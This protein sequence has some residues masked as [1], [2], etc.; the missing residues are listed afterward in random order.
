[1]SNITNNNST[2]KSSQIFK[3]L[4]R[5]KL[6]EKSP[7]QHTQR[8]S[9]SLIEMIEKNNNDSLMEGNNMNKE[10]KS[11][12]NT[13]QQS[14]KKKRKRNRRR[15]KK[16]SQ[17]I[18]NNNSNIG[19]DTDNCTNTDQD[20]KVLAIE[21][22]EINQSFNNL[23]IESETHNKNSLEVEIAPTKSFK[24]KIT[25][26]KNKDCKERFLQTSN[27]KEIN[28]RRT[29]TRKMMNK[30]VDES[31][32]EENFTKSKEDNRRRQK[33]RD[34]EFEVFKEF[35]NSLFEQIF[36]DSSFFQM[37]SSISTSIKDSLIL[38]NAGLENGSFW[39]TPYKK[40]A[41]NRKISC[42]ELGS[43]I[44][45][46]D[47]RKGSF[48]IGQQNDFA[49]NVPSHLEFNISIVKETNEFKNSKI[50][51]KI[52]LESNDSKSHFNKSTQR[53]KNKTKKQKR[54]ELKLMFSKLYIRLAEKWSSKEIRYW[55]DKLFPQLKSLHQQT[56]NKLKVVVRVI[57]EVLD[58]IF[59]KTGGKIAEVLR[60][61]AKLINSV[62]D[63]AI[64]ENLLIRVQKAYHLLPPCI[65]KHV[66]KMLR[67][68]ILGG[69][70]E[71][72]KKFRKKKA[73]R[74]DNL[75]TPMYLQGKGCQKKLSLIIEMG[76]RA[77]QMSLDDL[78]RRYPL[79]ISQ[80]DKNKKKFFRALNNKWNREMEN[81]LKQR[82]IFMEKR[83][84]EST[85]LDKR[86][87]NRIEII[88]TNKVR[89]SSANKK[90]GVIE[91]LLSE[92]SE[93]LNNF[94]TKRLFIVD[95]P[96]SDLKGS[97]INN[98]FDHPDNNKKLDTIV[99]NR[100]NAEIESTF[101]SASN[102]GDIE[103][104]AK[105]SRMGESI[106]L[107]DSINKPTKQ[108]RFSRNKRYLSEIKDQRKIN[109]LHS[110]LAIQRQ[111]R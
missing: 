72:D 88:S 7:N 25:N 83:R 49:K 62:N 66:Q 33:R 4:G 75:L 23:S 37:N 32:R 74:L 11:K 80:G 19:F 102:I 70:K 42:V 34:Q 46:I 28:K 89:I 14:K 15:K 65:N 44:P 90:Q 24:L 17:A 10:R 51:D 9:N 82:S 92:T 50:T 57:F 95:D 54:Q 64:Y 110:N 43:N 48:A 5:D 98:S 16:N 109:H 71:K 105:R 85:H 8:D 107:E 91:S 38:E 68:E 93:E 20:S 2:E 63:K 58:Q 111:E 27:P 59:P 53:K 41:P 12:T 81:S 99:Q 52:D 97:K 94:P 61:F 67:L 60:I 39:E 1:M 84:K 103:I 79:M 18:S 3:Q 104:L 45:K 108:S 26:V 21:L 100:K 77:D 36:E 47:V 13:S 86:K 35:T 69:K 6:T 76:Q 56:A 30:D 55:N 29:R 73:A 87:Q 22:D 96:E 40:K 101:E 31:D 106:E 78:T